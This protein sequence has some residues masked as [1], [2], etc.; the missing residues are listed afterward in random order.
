M[1]T[2]AASLQPWGV[3]FNDILATPLGKEVTVVGSKGGVLYV[4][5]TT[6]LEVPLGEKSPKDKDELAQLGYQRRPTSSHIQRTIDDRGKKRFQ[7]KLWLREF[8]GFMLSAAGEITPPRQ[9]PSIRP[10]TA[11]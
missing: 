2:D 4:K 5:W 1:L 11:A 9:M 7:E 8:G 6:G 10:Q 3:E